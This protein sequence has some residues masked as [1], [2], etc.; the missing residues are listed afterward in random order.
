MTAF[1]YY[2]V[3]MILCSGVLFLY[4]QVALRNRLFH[5]WNR[6]YL[7]VSVFLSLLLPLVRFTVFESDTE[8][9]NALDLLRSLQNADHRMKEF[10][11]SSNKGL[12]QEQWLF[13]LYGLVSFS[14]LVLF[15]LSLVRIFKIIRTHP[16]HHIKHTR[17]IETDVQG[18]PFSF[19]HFIFWN[20]QLS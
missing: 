14:L 8:Q 1:A 4:Y 19:F 18:T 17:L 7:L 11:V 15:S 10:I 12:S 20:R 2:L 6:F 13:M 5:Q 9:S 3:K 16:H